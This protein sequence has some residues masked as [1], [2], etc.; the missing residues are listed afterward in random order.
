[1]FRVQHTLAHP[2]VVSGPGLHTNQLARVTLRPAP[3]GHGRRVRGTG[4][5]ARPMTWEHRV[6]SLM[7]TSIGFADGRAVRTI[8]HLMA[9]LSACGVDNVEVEV[10]GPEVPI[11][12][13]SALPWCRRIEAAGLVPQEAPRAAIRVLRPVQVQRHGGFLRLEPADGFA[14][15]MTYSL[16]WAWPVTRWAGGLDRFRAELAPSR[17]FGQLDWRKLLGR[18]RGPV[19][20]P[21]GRAPV[22]PNRPDPSLPDDPALNAA[23]DA[24]HAAIDPRAPVLRGARPGRA[25]L[26]AGGMML[27]WGRVPDEPLRHVALDL[28]GDLALA[29]SPLVGRLVAH[30][31]SHEKTYMLVRALMTRPDAWTLD[32]VG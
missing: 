28:F 4:G 6:A 29:G 14:V 9:A 1:M 26:V 24:D 27:P 31:P 18:P 5:E 2:I 21:R 32:T 3:A 13:G 11:L 25:A 16:I 30:N 20:V 19:A 8:E 10:G 15:D 17:S 7:S 22:E 23:L 12:D